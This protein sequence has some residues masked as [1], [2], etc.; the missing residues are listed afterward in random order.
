MT[1]TTPVRSLF[2]LTLGSRV[3]CRHRGPGTVVDV[4]HSIGEPAV[5]CW[6]NTQHNYR[7]NMVVTVARDIDLIT[8]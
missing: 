5:V 6:D 1:T 4:P 7:A 8:D 2:S 3:V